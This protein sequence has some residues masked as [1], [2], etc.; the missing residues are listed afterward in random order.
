MSQLKP[1]DQQVVVVMGAS[2]GIGRAA[3][4]RFAAEG[5]KVVVSARGTQGLN[6][7]VEQIRQF[8]GE[9]TA[10]PADVTDFSQVQAVANT[11]VERYGR[12][13]TWVHVAAV[14]LYATFEDTTIEEFRQ[15]L[16]VNL[17]GQVHGA[18]AAL[19]HLRQEGRGALIHVS[20]IE[21]IRALPYQAAYAASKHGVKGFLE[22]L[23][24]ELAHEGLAI[25]V[26]N[27]M[28]A[29]INTPLFNHA[30]TKIGTKPKGL[31]P[32]YEPEVVVEAIAHAAAH[33]ERDIFAGGAARVF[34]MTQAF[35]PKLLDTMM[36][37][38]AFKGQ[39]TNEPKGVDAPDNLFEPMDAYHTVYGDFGEQALGPGPYSPAETMDGLKV[40]LG[41]LLLGAVA[42]MAWRRLGSRA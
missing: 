21:A 24:M 13:D 32:I 34:A 10:V 14:S 18:K 8:G 42:A 20:S 7:L 28:P 16:D 38:T 41:S 40:G 12:L 5:A 11:A 29:T 2:S 25:S 36:L 23:R 1:V 4:L 33:P 35:S 27:V 22:S 3:A 9:A 30:R 19:P 15:L 17:M 37:A 6:S 26:T 39:R 31:P